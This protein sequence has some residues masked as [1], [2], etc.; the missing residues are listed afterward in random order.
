MKHKKF[1]KITIVLLYTISIFMSWGGMIYATNEPDC[2]R[3]I[4]V[5]IALLG[6][7]VFF[8]TVCL[9]ENTDSE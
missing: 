6:Y 1:I 8:G 2:F 7:G 3:P 9:Y 4:G 5:V